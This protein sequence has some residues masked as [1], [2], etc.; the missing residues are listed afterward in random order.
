MQITLLLH[1]E[2]FPLKYVVH[3]ISV[4]SC[5]MHFVYAYENQGVSINTHTVVFMRAMCSSNFP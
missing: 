5:H 4:L 1:L 3:I 2:K